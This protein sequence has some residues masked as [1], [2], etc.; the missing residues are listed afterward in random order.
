MARTSKSASP[1]KKEPTKTVNEPVAEAKA[2]PSVEVWKPS[3]HMTERIPMRSAVYGTLIYVDTLS[4]R[5]WEWSG[6]GQRH[7]L[8]LE[9]LENARNSQ[10]AFFVN[11]WWEIDA[12]YE[13]AQE[14]LEFLD[15]TQFYRSEASID[16]FDSLLKRSAAEVEAV[17]NKLPV[18]QRVSL[19][20]RAQELI[21][22]GKLDSISVIR[23]LEKTLGTEFEY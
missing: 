15:A 21:T 7:E 2:A 10:P 17:I 16:N 4:H 11:G 12:E 8:T 6:Y 13:H 23:V 1:A 14:V 18:T 5:K 19:S 20:R 9:A 3:E 22:A